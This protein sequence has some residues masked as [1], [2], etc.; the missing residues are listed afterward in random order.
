MGLELTS[1]ARPH[2]GH[3]RLL[4]AVALALCA[5]YAA[6]LAAAFLAGK[7]LVDGEGHARA[8]DFVGFWAAG[9]LALD[10]HAA[11]S[12]DLAAHKAAEEAAVGH[13]ID[14]DFPFF[15]PPTFL[16]PAALVA[17]VPYAAAGAAWTGATLIPYLAA[18]RAIIGERRGILLA[19]AFPAVWLNLLFSQNGFLTAA[20]LAAIL[21]TMETRPALAGALLGLLAC[22]PQLGLLFPLVLGASGRWRVFLVAA[23]VAATLAASAALIFG[24][25]AWLA[26]LRSLPVVSVGVLAEGRAEFAKLQSIFGL[27]RT[28]GGPAGLAWALHGCVAVASAVAV[29]WLW[30]RPGAFEL[31]A[32]AL[33]TATLAATPYLFAYDL[34]ALVVPV[35]FLIRQRR[36][37][38]LLPG[39][40]AALGAIAALS[41]SYGMMAAPVGPP[42]MAI[43]AM[44]IAR[45]VRA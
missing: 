8:S 16:F 29:C 5:A 6:H 13:S 41:L 1:D 34:V 12:Y 4:A 33:V 3:D 43:V 32:A 25:E 40:T 10:G 15:Y 2:R 27:V 23:A 19:A 18:V 11:G 44:M 9:R 45:R 22:K 38:S 35:A 17:L 30:R 31:K 7:W 14:G 28:L 26:F 20:L 24:A 39:E 42:A 36:G 21:N 37:A